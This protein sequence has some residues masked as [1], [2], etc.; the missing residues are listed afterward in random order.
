MP[1]YQ[2]GGGR[3]LP[4][5]AYPRPNPGQMGLLSDE[6]W[7]V[8]QFASAEGR[9]ARRRQGLSKSK[10][11]D[12]DSKDEPT[13]LPESVIN[14]YRERLDQ[15]GQ[16]FLARGPRTFEEQFAYAQ[17][18]RPNAHENST[19]ASPEVQ[20]RFRQW[21]HVDWANNFV[22]PDGIVY[23]RD[24]WM[25]E[26]K[27]EARIFRGYESAVG[28]FKRPKLDDLLDR[29][30]LPDRLEGLSPETQAKI[31]DVEGF[32]RPRSADQAAWR[33]W[34]HEQGVNPDTWSPAK[35][36]PDDDQTHYWLHDSRD[37][38]P[39]VRGAVFVGPDGHTYRHNDL[40]RPDQSTKIGAALEHQRT[41]AA[42]RDA[43]PPTF[44]ELYDRA[45]TS[46]A[47]FPGSNLG[48][49]YAGPSYGRSSVAKPRGQPWQAPTVQEIARAL[50]RWGRLG[51]PKTRALNAR[52]ARAGENALWKHTHGA[53][54]AGGKRRRRS[55]SRIR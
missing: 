23:V 15:E 34:A 43:P 27:P 14:L 11:V 32:D 40:T 21:R 52:L 46:G 47:L 1:F 50:K 29:F 53:T 22:G 3:A 37:V 20:L 13:G 31:R 2:G 17:Q 36:L 49:G 48:R 30:D 45:L 10:P 44:A 38:A 54:D 19:P 16:D 12:A 5:M 28:G 24:R 33:D 7:P 41:V 35:R 39:V 9:F 26:E 51:N 4:S 42:L 55:T 8:P 25:G 6:L 18:V